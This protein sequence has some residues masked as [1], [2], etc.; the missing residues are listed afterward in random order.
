MNNRSREE[1]APEGKKKC[2]EEMIAFVESVMFHFQW[3]STASASYLRLQLTEAQ[4]HRIL[5]YLKRNS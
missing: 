4:P 5:W 1:V 2:L 3:L